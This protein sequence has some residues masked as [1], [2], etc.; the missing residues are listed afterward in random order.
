M[1]LDLM[2]QVGGLAQGAT[3]EVA[4]SSHHDRELAEKWCARTGNTLVSTD[5]DDAGVG[6]VVVRRG[7]PPDPA[8]VLGA[9]RLP[10][11]RLWLYTN[12]H[13]N[14]S[15]DYC[16]VSSSPQAAHRELGSERIGRIVGEAARWGVRELFLTGG[17][18]F[19]LPDIATIIS[20]CVET[21]PTTVLTNGMVFKGRAAGPWIPCP[22]MGSHCRSAWTRRRR[23]CTT[24]T[25]APVRGK[26]RLPESVSRY[27]W[28][29]GY[30]W[31]RQSPPPRPANWPHFTS[32]SMRSVSQARIS[33]C[34]RSP[35]K[36][37][38][39]RGCRCAANRSFRR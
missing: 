8:E 22:G 35:W 21:L 24:R 20:A 1:I 7:H 34:G 12:F 28:V 29:S 6:A 10:G 17:E 14:L 13:C 39:P 33:W 32:S 38:R 18:P 36:V 23:T 3:V 19:L 26:R 37:L 4:V 15:C 5:L 27:R 30:A 16:C 31:P 25:A 2:R 11:V 9:D